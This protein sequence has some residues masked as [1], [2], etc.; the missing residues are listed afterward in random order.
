MLTLNK[1]R[2]ALYGIQKRAFWLYASKTKSA[3]IYTQ[4]SFSFSRSDRIQQYNKKQTQEELHSLN[5]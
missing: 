4:T 3:Q 1:R 2:I 5:S